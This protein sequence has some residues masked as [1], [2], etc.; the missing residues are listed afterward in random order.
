MLIPIYTS[1]ND[2]DILATDFLNRESG[3]VG[4]IN[5]A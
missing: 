3:M 5:L 2:V 1:G 4:L